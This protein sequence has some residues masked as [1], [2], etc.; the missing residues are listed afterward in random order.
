METKAFSTPTMLQRAFTLTKQAN[1]QQ[2]STNLTV[3]LPNQGSYP[4][5]ASVNSDV[6]T[7]IM[8]SPRSATFALVPQRK[9]DFLRAQR[10][11]QLELN[12]RCAKISTT[13]RY[14]PKFCQDLVRDLASQLRRI[15]KPDYLNHVRYKTIVL[16]N[17]VQT[18]PNRQIHQ[19][20]TMV[21]RC[22]WNH[23]TD[24]SIT[25]ETKLGFDMLAIATAFAIYTD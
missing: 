23:E 22:L 24:G 1:E 21:S 19:A 20:I 10:L 8:P 14:D 16:V 15:I 13:T 18:K 17:I 5:Q 3:P 25:V 12:R 7:S 2:L 6:T 4:R 9:F 11:L